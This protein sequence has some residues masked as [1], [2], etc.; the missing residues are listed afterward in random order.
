MSDDKYDPTQ[1]AEALEEAADETFEFPAS[2]AQQRLWFL[3]QLESGS[4]FYNMSFA[5]RFHGRLNVGALKQ[6]LGEVVRR[7]EVLRTT[8][9]SEDGQPVQVVHPPAPVE[10]PTVDLTH[11]PEAEREEEARRLA[12]EEARRPFD[13]STGP[14]LRVTLLRLGEEDHVVLFMMHHIVCDGWSMSVLMREVTALYGAYSEG[15]ES[16]LEELQVQYADFAVWQREW[17]QG[18]VLEK[19]LG[20]WRGQLGGELP[21]LELPTDRPRPP[22]QSYRGATQSI[23]L[24]GEVSERLRALSRQ[25]GV[26]L[27]MVLLAAYKALLA[28]YSGQDDIITGTDI[29]N[30]NRAETEDLIGFFV[31]QLVL[32]TDL[33]GNPTFR[34]LVGRVREVTLGAYAHQ[35][36]PFEKLVEELAPER[37]MSRSPLFQVKFV[38]QNAPK[39]SL[40]FS[41][42]KLG[43][44]P[45][46]SGRAKFDLTLV[47]VDK[48]QGIGGAL[49]YNIDLF[50]AETITRLLRHFERLVEA[51][52]ADPELRLSELPLLTDEE[53]A[54]L[55][56]EWNDT[57]REYPNECI[58]RTFERQAARTPD[59]VAVSSDEGEL[60]Y[61]ELNARSNQLAR[62]LRRLGVGAESRVGLCLGRS[63]EMVVGIL[64]IL[65]AGGAYVP[66]DAEYP[67]ERLL[68]MLE[69]A[70][71]S[72]VLTESG[73]AERLPAHWA[74]VVSLDEERAQWAGEETSNLDVAG[75]GFEGSPDSLAYVIYTSGS[76]GRPKGVEVLHRGVSRL[77]FPASYASLPDPCVTLQLA[78]VSFDAST[79]ELWAA[80]L[81]GGRCVLAPPAGALSAAE[82]SALLSRHGVGVLWLT[83]SL[84]NGVVE[85]DAGALAG[86]ERLLVGGEA[87]SP[88][89]VRMALAGDWGGKLINGYGPTE[90]T[91]FACCYEISA[92]EAEEAADGGRG[93]SIGGPIEN[94]RAFV[95]D[96]W[97]APAPVGVVGELYLGGDGLARGYL[98]RPALTAE[99][100]V[101]DAF[102]TEP[103]AR[104]YRTGDLVKW[105]ADGEL[106]F[107]GRRDGQV[108]V[109]GFRIEVGEVEAAL[110]AHG[111]VSEA[112]VVIREDEPGD[113]RL[114][115]YVV[116]AEGQAVNVTGLR[117]HLRGRLP[118][119][120]TPS[121]F[122]T[123]DALPLT[124]SGKLDR[125][126]LPAPGGERPDLGEEYVAPRTEAEER[127]AGIW[128]EVLRVERVGVTDNF[129]E[130][131][132]HSLLATQVVSRVREAFQVELPL[133]AIFESPTVEQLVVIISELQAEQKGVEI[134][135]IRQAESADEE[136]LLE[137][138]EELSEEELTRLYAT[139]VGGSGDGGER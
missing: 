17:L 130:L 137:Q 64:S 86:V 80:L 67:A 112:A 93:L 83:A 59:A 110:R 105:R 134:S 88:R 8:F 55:L 4:H 16:P 116:A 29:A 102:S 19:Q 32:R 26:T 7:H 113:K 43:S 65:K 82:L 18:E 22:V 74:Q 95:V 20:Y 41:G 25:E 21:V 30:R 84:F 2:F 124:P 99:R 97:G 24:S 138:L 79:F 73:L 94:T 131:G 47:M 49:E 75:G 11:L 90:S 13:L 139:M 85:E 98:N 56:G 106:E 111:G 89:H 27:F 60:S 10:L 71:V 48:E 135:T 51:A 54:R 57:R 70:G 114:V 91:T 37:D 123:L 76:T 23:M 53:L 92:A 136:R 108:K 127:L 77:V 121:A 129:F 122:V 9:A 1:S 100:F 36:V 45:I 66:L 3:D 15:R 107:V 69:D 72:V 52:S 87:L 101:P 38:L 68:Y 14:L 46:E 35:D 12:G 132:G 34:E 109:R 96:A 50:D 115:A 125:R 5:V 63:S 119:Y 58:H 104:L 28:R 103:G 126:A 39:G 44:L 31:N 133:R 118:E 61:A 6:T 42:L 33:S 120:M 128:R 78:P 62:H 117:E 40:G 81:R